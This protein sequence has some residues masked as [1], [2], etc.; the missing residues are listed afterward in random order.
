MPHSVSFDGTKL[1][2]VSPPLHPPLFQPSLRTVTCQSQRSQCFQPFLCCVLYHRAALCCVLGDVAC[3]SPILGASHLRPPQRCCV[4][5]QKQRPEA[6]DAHRDPGR[7]IG[8]WG[9]VCVFV[10]QVDSCWWSSPRCLAQGLAGAGAGRGVVPSFHV[11]FLCDSLSYRLPSMWLI[12]L[13]RA[14]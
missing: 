1:V 2:I 11:W 10:K 12:F 13:A 6:K 5:D 3:D 7:L 4:L 9:V 8:W 14:V